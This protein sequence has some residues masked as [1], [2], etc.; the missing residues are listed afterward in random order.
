M[1]KQILAAVAAV[2]GLTAMNAQQGNFF[3]QVSIEAAYGY[4]VALTP[5]HLTLADFNGLNTLQLGAAY[6]INPLWGVRGTYSNTTFKHKDN[7]NLGITY[8]KLTAEATFNI[9]EAISPSTMPM[10]Q[11]FELSAHAGFGLNFGK[12]KVTDA[13]DNIGN[14]Q[15]GVRPQYNV[16]RTV[17]VFL[18]GTYIMNFKQH[19]DY[20]GM[21]LTGSKETTGG[22]V[23]ALLGVAVKL[24][25]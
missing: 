5:S 3:D 22:Y 24:G 18:D 10:V 4:N 12:S 17:G 11:A 9:L 19:L 16:S 23:T 25:K 21:A 7:S 6:Q 1:K 8:N 2:F 15:I 13:V 14:F 20:N